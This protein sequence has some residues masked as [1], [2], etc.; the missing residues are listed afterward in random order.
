MSLHALSLF[1]LLLLV[2][3]GKAG[4]VM[5]P[6]VGVVTLDGEPMEGA[7][8]MFMPVAGGRPASGVTDGAGRYQLRTREAN[9]G[10]VT[11]EYNVSIMLV[12]T[13]GIQATADGLPG[14]SAPGGIKQ[15]WIIPKRYSKP[16]TSGLKATVAVGQREHNFPLVS[17]SVPSR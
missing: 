5:I 14:G 16:D 1:G 8:V 10:A 3:C 9:D 6:T 13:T 15:E 12:K 4:P 7:A 11:G 2:G 17:G